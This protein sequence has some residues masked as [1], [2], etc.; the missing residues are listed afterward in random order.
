MRRPA[1]INSKTFAIV[2]LAA[3]ILVVSMDLV[4]LTL[5]P[6]SLGVAL[7]LLTVSGGL[8]LYGRSKISDPKP[9]KK[10]RDIQR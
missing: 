4:T 8:W 1:E 5:N 9:E 2:A 6:E 10:K 7:A 3:A